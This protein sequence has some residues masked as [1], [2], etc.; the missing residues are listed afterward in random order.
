MSY[1]YLGKESFGE[2]DIWHITMSGTGDIEKTGL[3]IGAAAGHGNVGNDFQGFGYGKNTYYGSE[4]TI[5]CR[6]GNKFYDEYE[7]E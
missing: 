2:Q 3:A 1:E 6:G 7:S 4:G 5:E